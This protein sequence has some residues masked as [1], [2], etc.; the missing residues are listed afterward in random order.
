MVL[1]FSEGDQ[2]AL[3]NLVIEPAKAGS[4]IAVVAG[5]QRLAVL[6]DPGALAVGI[7]GIYELVDE[8]PQQG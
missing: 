8:I 6:L 2:R 5:E 1:R 3:A 4:H 7:V